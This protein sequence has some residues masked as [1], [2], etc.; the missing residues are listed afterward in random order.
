MESELLAVHTIILLAALL[1][2][3]AVAALLFVKRKREKQKHVFPGTAVAYFPPERP[4]RSTRLRSIAALCAGAA[5]SAVFWRSP[6]AVKPPALPTVPTAAAIGPGV[7]IAISYADGSG[8][9]GCT[10]GFLVRTSA[11]RYAL[12]TAGHCNLP[13]GPGKVSIN[14]SGTG[15]YE[16][17]GTFTE[18]VSERDAWQ[19]HDIALITLDN[20]RMI[21]LT[22]GIAD[23]DSLTGVTSNV[24]VRQQLCHFGIRTRKQCGP[25]VM[26]KTGKVAFAAPSTCGD[27]GG[28]VYTVHRDGSTVAIGVM[29]AGSNADYSK[30]SCAVTT[31]FSV[32]ELIGPW[33]DKWH[34]TVVT[35]V[36]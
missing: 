6:G 34:L 12:L 33:L 28:P 3:F 13:G 14:Y 9:N 24:A 1:T 31:R 4:R 20:A 29:V 35:A 2:C 17:V 27:S 32:A 15:S 36:G 21:P 30:P 26:T 7:G 11:G 18:T 22:S 5:L 8:S 16:T 23:L 10:A 19:D 25:I